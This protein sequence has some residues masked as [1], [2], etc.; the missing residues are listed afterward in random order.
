MVPKLVFTFLHFTQISATRQVLHSFNISLTIYLFFL[1]LNHFDWFLL[2]IKV[3]TLWLIP[4]HVF[5]FLH[6]TQISTT[7]WV[8][9][10]YS[11]FNISFKFQQL[12]GSS[13]T[14]NIFIILT[15]CTQTFTFRSI[16]TFILNFKTILIG[17][18]NFLHKF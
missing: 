16:L 17:F 10:S 3:L 18:R 8:L 9:L 14:V 5:K 6:F 2:F 1:K 13:S 4:K 11:T 12:A 7:R 15:F